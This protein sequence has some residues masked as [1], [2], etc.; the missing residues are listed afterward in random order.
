MATSYSTQIK[1]H[2]NNWVCNC[3]NAYNAFKTINEPQAI[4]VT[5]IL[6]GETFEFNC[7]LCGNQDD[8]SLIDLEA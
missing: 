5:D 8:L 3:G 6:N 7:P 2:L 1:A 4:V